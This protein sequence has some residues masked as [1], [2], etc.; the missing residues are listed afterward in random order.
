MNNC[1]DIIN[2]SKYREDYTGRVFGKLTVI[3]VT[4]RNGKRAWLCKCECGNETI[5]TTG[6]LKNTFSCGCIKKLDSPKIDYSYKQIDRL[7]VL[8][9]YRRGKK[10]IWEWKIKCI[11]GKEFWGKP[12]NLISDLKRHGVA[13]CGCAKIIYD[14]SACRRLY[15]RYKKS[16]K[17]RNLEF[18][19]S[20]GVFKEITKK[21]CFYCGDEPK[22]IFNL[23]RPGKNSSIV[24]EYVYNGVDRRDNTKGYIDENI[25]PCCTI[26]NQSKL[27]RTEDA[28][29]LMVKKVYENR[30]VSSAQMASQTILKIVL[31]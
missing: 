24:K 12:S 13:S 10:G 15:I 21:K 20:Y 16:A 27:N 19:M 4:I 29:L 18:T 3:S 22:Q 23:E 2:E 1:T 31:P 5:V 17:C 25:V 14:N 9:E 28:F 8:P 30:L 26:C 7:T 11:C 6:N